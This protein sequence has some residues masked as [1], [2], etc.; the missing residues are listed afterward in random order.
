MDERKLKKID[1]NGGHV[2]DRENSQKQK[3][4]EHEIK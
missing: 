4:F 2:M 1:K 3:K